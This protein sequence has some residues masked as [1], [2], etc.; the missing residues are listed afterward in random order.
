MTTTKLLFLRIYLITL[1]RIPLFSQILRKL[2]E[3]LLIYRG[4]ER[5]VAQS[6]YF[7]WQKL[8]S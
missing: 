5:Y 6:K 4:K 2:L 1:G 7:D 3:L 8:K